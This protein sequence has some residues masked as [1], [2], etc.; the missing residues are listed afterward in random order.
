ME[1]ALIHSLFL[2]LEGM[3]LGV[4]G[5]DE[6]VDGVAHLPGRGKAGPAQ[7]ATAED[8]EPD[9]DQVE[10]ACIGGCKVKVDVGMARQPA[11]ALGLVGVE[12]VQ[13]HVNGLVG[14]ILVDQFVHEV[15]ELPA[16]AS[17]GMPGLDVAGG[18]LQGGQTGS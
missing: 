3:G 18:Y 5:G 10:P 13:N 7:G 2:P 8:A 17:L 1:P 9:L 6:G 12:V 4:V 16:S 15:E 11:V 14:W